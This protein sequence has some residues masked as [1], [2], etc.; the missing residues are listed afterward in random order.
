MQV[1]FVRV[2]LPVYN[3]AHCVADAIE[4]VRAQTYIDWELI[5]IDDGSV[6]GSLQILRKFASEDSRIKVLSQV[7]Q[8]AAAARNRGMDLEGEC[9]FVAFIDSDDTWEPYH[10][11]DALSV[12]Q[13]HPDVD[14]VFGRT[15]TEEI[16]GRLSDEGRESRE[17]HLNDW[18]SMGQQVHEGATVFINARSMLNCLLVLEMCPHTPTVVIRWNTL[19]RHRFPSPFMVLEDV[20]LWCELAASGITFAFCDR[21]Q[22]KVR[23]FGDNLTKEH[24]LRD[25][26]TLKNLDSVRRFNISLLNHCR[27][28]NQKNA[29]TRRLATTEYLRG[30][31]YS[32]QNQ[33]V[34]AAL[35]YLRSI[36]YGDGWRSYRSLLGLV[37]PEPCKELLRRKRNRSC[38]PGAG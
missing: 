19:R 16:N 33:P 31:C 18:K 12:L 24:G 34:S 23:L 35:T 11:E 22:A 32:E 26:R 25:P 29:V 27:T 17:R 5:A 10:L 7:N 9:D 30:Q 15:I 4:S 37:I 3:R 28:A 2:I 14:F 6:D 8:G 36:W 13:Q 1:N 38:S 20:L 21:R